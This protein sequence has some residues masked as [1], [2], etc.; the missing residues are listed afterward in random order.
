MV[1]NYYKCE[2]QNFSTFKFITDV[3]YDMEL[4][5]DQLG[6]LH[7][8]IDE[9]RA[10]H[11][12]RAEGQQEK[13]NNLNKKLAKVGELTKESE[14]D[15]EKL[16][17]KLSSMMQGVFKLFTLCKCSQ[18]PLLKLLGNNSTIN[19]FNV[20]LYLQILEQ[21]I[22]EYLI[23]AGYKDKFI[24]SYFNWNIIEN[25]LCVLE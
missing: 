17:N 15:L 4:V 6:L 1:Q 23:R 2:A 21:T 12:F 18:D 14:Q 20:I 7:L 22:H 16:N 9:Q 10:T 5:N 3:I 19:C 13:L 24:V 11:V 25:K 8:D